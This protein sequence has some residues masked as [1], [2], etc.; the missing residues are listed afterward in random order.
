MLWQLI[1]A[2]ILIIALDIAL[3]GIQ[4][5]NLFQLQGAFKRC[6]YGIKLKV[7]FV[8]FNRLRRFVLGR[9]G[10]E[11]YLMSGPESIGDGSTHALRPVVPKVWLGPS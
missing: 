1:Y 5:A 4:C 11:L 7:E 8:I 2:N 9:A 3:V 6:V 10:T